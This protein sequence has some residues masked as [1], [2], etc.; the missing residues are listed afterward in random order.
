V[1][2]RFCEIIARL[3]GRAER[4]RTTVAGEVLTAS[5]LADQATDEVVD[6]ARSGARLHL[7]GGFQEPYREDRPRKP[8]TNEK[9][10]RERLGVPSDAADGRQRHKQ[11]VTGMKQPLTKHDHRKAD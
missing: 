8:H 5:G 2:E 11:A 9:E 1:V 7:S 6:P 10:G 4:F 3:T